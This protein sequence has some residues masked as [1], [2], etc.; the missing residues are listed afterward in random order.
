MANY[1][2]YALLRNRFDRDPVESV[3]QMELNAKGPKDGR[4]TIPTTAKQHKGM[5]SVTMCELSAKWNEIVEALRENGVKVTNPSHALE[6]ALLIRYCKWF[7]V[8]SDS[9][10]S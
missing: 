8:G 10:L 3:R 2:L 1:L 9:S 7:H 6:G 5:Q 4:T